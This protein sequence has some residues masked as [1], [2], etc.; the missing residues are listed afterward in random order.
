MQESGPLQDTYAQN[1]DNPRRPTGESFIP[2]GHV[3]IEAHKPED[4]ARLGLSPTGVVWLHQLYISYALQKG[5]FGAAATSK[6]EDVASREPLRANLMVLDSISKETQFKPTV[7][8]ALYRDRDVPVPAV[9]LEAVY[10][11]RIDSNLDVL[12]IY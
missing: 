9:S 1:Q 2:I 4:N 5:G 3:A 8:K 11:F 12:G 10:P 6:I 7:Q